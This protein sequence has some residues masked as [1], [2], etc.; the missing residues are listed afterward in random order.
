[1]SN[2]RGSSAGASTRPSSSPVSGISAKRG[3]ASRRSRAMGAKPRGLRAW[4][5]DLLLGREG[6]A[7]QPTPPPPRPPRGR[8][9]LSGRGGALDRLRERYGVQDDPKEA[10]DGR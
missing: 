1:S 3:P 9:R 4:L 8:G 2:W 6:P 10:A 7:P 5:A